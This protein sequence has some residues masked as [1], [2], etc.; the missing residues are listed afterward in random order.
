MANLPPTY[1]KYAT[2][3]SLKK[4]SK[5]FIPLERRKQPNSYF[6]KFS[7]FPNPVLNTSVGSGVRIGKNRNFRPGSSSSLGSTTSSVDYTPYYDGSSTMTIPLCQPFVKIEKNISQ[8]MHDQ[9]FNL[10]QV[11][12][13]KAAEGN[14]MI[15]STDLSKLTN[16]PIE[17]FVQ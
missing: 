12:R 11:M 1:S 9:V 10:Q 6:P 8:K 14:L 5:T 2:L 16:Q 7:N 13:A 3:L 15:E 4:S 17:L